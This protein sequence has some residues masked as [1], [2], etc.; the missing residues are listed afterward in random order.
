LKLITYRQL[1]VREDL[2]QSKSPSKKYMLRLKS[3]A[4]AQGLEH[5]ILN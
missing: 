4:Q 2:L 1:G 3:V 5:V